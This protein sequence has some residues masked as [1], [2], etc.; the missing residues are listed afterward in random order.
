MT[1]TDKSLGNAIN[2]EIRRLEHIITDGKFTG[3]LLL[4][5][6]SLLFEHYKNAVH[7]FENSVREMQRLK[8]QLIEMNRS[9]DLA[10]RIDPMTGLANRRDIMD[11]IEQEH[12]RAQRHQRT[13]SI[14]MVDIDDFKRIND[15]YGIN[16][17]D[18]VLFEIACVLRECVRS[19]DVC[20]RW[21]G[22]EFLFLLPETGIEG[23]LN[24]A[25]KINQSVAMT[26]FKANKPGIRTTVS[27]GVCEYRTGQT[28]YDCLSRAD[29]ALL[30]AKQDGKNR[31]IVAV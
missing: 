24:V 8:T 26:E 19:E 28:I 5:E 29:Q 3:N 25:Q 2:D 20:S 7:K 9:L 21:G 31:Y 22:E 11:K 12:S 15:T 10:T 27:L 16:A 23:A 13:Y 17:G 30:Q 1:K 6:F 18:D 14:I 4:P